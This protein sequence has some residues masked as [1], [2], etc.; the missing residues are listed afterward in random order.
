MANE[1]NT[2]LPPQDLESES[3]VL[4]ALML[5]K[6]A[7]LK[8]VDILEPDDFY[9]P[10]H[11]KIFRVILDLFKNSNPI[12]LLTV[13]NKLKK[14][15]QLKEIGGSDYLTELINK[16]PTSAHI[17]HYAKIVKENKIRRDLISASSD[18]NEDAIKNTDFEN[19]L[20]AV[21]QKIF[22]ISQRSRTQ[23]F[24]HL[25]EELPRAY[26]RLEKLHQGEKE[27]IL[28]GVTSGFPQLDK[29]LS[30][31]Q[32]SDLII[33]GARPSIGKT[34]LALDIARNAALKNYKVGIFSLEMSA[35]QVVDRIIATQSQIP[36]WR[37]RTGR[38]QNETEFAMIQQALSV[39]S[40][41]S[42]FIEDSPSPNILHIRSMARKL[43][44]EHGLDLLII[45]YLQLITPRTG[46]NSIVQQITEISRSLK[47]LARELEVP[48]LALSQLSRSVEQREIKIPRL[49]DLR[50]SG[51]LEQDSDVV[52]LIYR[53]NQGKPDISDEERNITDI[54]IAK[55]RNGPL[56]AIKLGFDPERVSFRTIDTYHEEE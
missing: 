50:E 41:I 30:G 17:S 6:N 51:S 52:M 23:K 28:R 45:D 31:F 39:L 56:G 32:K 36:L 2:K 20:D 13:T 27:N 25:K 33:L 18:I 5:D 43:Q 11:Q 44:L 42:L 22:K 38:I 53:K 48:V 21:E 12:D 29:I 4:G 16:V 1:K 15:N 7:I 8:V 49:S 54:I 40:N 10:S 34:S 47:S 55:H 35:E 24:T 14:E 46:S 3:S 9:H 26:E 37:L 19:L